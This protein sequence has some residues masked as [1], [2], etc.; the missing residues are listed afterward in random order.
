MGWV[1]ALTGLGLII[2]PV[3][4]SSLYGLL[5]YANTFFI[6]GAFL[7]VLAIIIKMNFPDDSELELGDDDDNFTSSNQHLHGEEM[8]SFRNDV[9]PERIDQADNSDDDTESGGK[10]VTMSALLCNARFLMAALASALVYFCYS[11]M[12]PILAERLTDFDL[13]SMQIGLFF[14]IYAL[15]YIPAS[16]A[17]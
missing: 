13:N 16:I 11:F 17:V 12:E 5:G 8:S 10:E 4:G 9:T 15:F 7:I 14:T 2:G 1:E 6:Y 3:V